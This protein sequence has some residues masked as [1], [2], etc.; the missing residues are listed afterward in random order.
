MASA[1]M[2][3][4][5]HRG[6]DR[7]VPGNTLESFAAAVEAGVDAIEF[8]VVWT[9]GASGPGELMVAHDLGDLA[10][11]EHPT[12]AETLDAFARPPLNGVDID[13]DIKM[14]GREAEIV[15]AIRQVGLAD[16]AMFS[17]MELSS[18]HALREL[19]PDMRRGWTLPRINRDPRRSRLTKPFIK[20]GLALL[21]RR[22]PR[23]IERQAKSLDVWSVWLLH[24]LAT[25]RVIAA[26]HAHG[27]AVFAWTVDSAA[28]QRELAELGVDGLV[29]NDPRLF[30]ESLAPSASA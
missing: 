23:L 16:R 29:S 6:A 14:A 30:E 4:V 18:I 22:L 26:A 17:G 5:G 9:T 25:P 1:P 19:A 15:A 3:R 24:Y 28:R 11:R 27:L 20:P 13:V 7:I 12:L 10:A 21:E 8:D 2:I